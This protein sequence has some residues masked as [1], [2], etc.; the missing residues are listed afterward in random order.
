MN[1]PTE[2]VPATGLSKFRIG[3]ILWRRGWRTRWQAVRVW[4]H[5]YHG[6]LDVEI[7]DRGYRIIAASPFEVGLVKNGMGLRTWYATEF[8]GKL[9]RLDHPIIQAAIKAQEEMEAEFKMKR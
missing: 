3:R 1:E 8:G 6:E 2:T 5:L 4:L 9:P 7:E